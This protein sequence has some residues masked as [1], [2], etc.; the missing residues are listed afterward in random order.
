MGE[1]LKIQVKRIY[2]SPERGDGYRMLV[3]RLWPRGISKERA[4]LDEWNKTLAPSA[5]LRKWFHHQNG[6]F[7]EFSAFY[8]QELLGQ[9]AELQR[10]REL[11]ETRKI[12]LLYASKDP[13]HNH[14]V[15]LY[16]VLK[17]L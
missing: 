17:R 6:D 12:T 7:A 8:R 16:D 5:S 9:K 10:V 1:R 15:V 13:A 3:D 14:A 2:E 4:H 11:G